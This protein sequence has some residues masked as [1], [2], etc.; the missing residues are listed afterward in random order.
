MVKVTL[1]FKS[2]F[3]LLQFRTVAQAYG[4]DVDYRQLSIAGYFSEIDIKLAKSAY[5]AGL[6]EVQLNDNLGKPELSARYLSR[7]HRL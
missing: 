6:R 2:L 5:H 7:R 3:E 4:A 1:Q